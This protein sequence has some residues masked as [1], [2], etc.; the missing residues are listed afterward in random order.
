MP[1]P[2]FPLVPR[3]VEGKST[4]HKWQTTCPVCN[5]D[6]R[7]TV[8]KSAYYSEHTCSECEASWH[9]HPYDGYDM[10]CLVLGNKCGVCRL[11]EDVQSK[12]PRKLIQAFR[13]DVDETFVDE[14]VGGGESIEFVERIA[15]THSIALDLLCPTDPKLFLKSE[16]NELECAPVLA[17]YAAACVALD[18]PSQW[19][20]PQKKKYKRVRVEAAQ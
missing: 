11:P 15:R 20:G 5:T 2:A 18:T 3:I 7:Y 4:E 9:M 6:T 1:L 12:S 19:S 8:G 10:L 14:V 13:D 16:S 17:A